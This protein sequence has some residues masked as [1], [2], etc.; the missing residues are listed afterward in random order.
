VCNPPP[1]SA[2]APQRQRPIVLTNAFPGAPAVRAALHYRRGGEWRDAGWFVLAP[3][4][5]REVGAS[6]AGAPVLY[7]AEAAPLVVGEDA[8]GVPLWRF[9]GHPNF[10]P[11]ARTCD[12]HCDNCFAID[13]ALVCGLESDSGDIVFDAEHV[14][15]APP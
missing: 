9:W 6:D 12:G 8:D 14:N 4:E 2:A 1:P 15:T 11:T 3:G 7:Y 13:G 10:I 5:A